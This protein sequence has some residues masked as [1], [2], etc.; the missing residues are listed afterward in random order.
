MQFLKVGETGNHW[1][2]DPVQDDVKEIAASMWWYSEPF[3]PKAV[4]KF[5][6][7]SGITENPKVF[8]KV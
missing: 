7:V 6:D 2:A 1:T 3:S 8:Q 5:Y 4:P